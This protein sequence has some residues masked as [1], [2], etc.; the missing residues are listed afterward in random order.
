MRFVYTSLPKMRRFMRNRYREESGLRRLRA[1]RWLLENCNDSQLANVFNKKA[2]EVATLKA[3]LQ[4]NVGKLADW[5][6]KREL[7]IASEAAAQ[8]AQAE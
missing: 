7:L 6:A 4:A 2:G 5:E 8:A 3:R 1:A